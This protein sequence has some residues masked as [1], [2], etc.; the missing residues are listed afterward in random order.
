MA[1]SLPP[2]PPSPPS[3]PP[4]PPPPPP[5]AVQPDPLPWEKPDYPAVE[6][7]YETAKLFL[8]N[9]TAA[10]ARMS[11]TGSL[12]R[13]L[14][15]AIILGWVGIIFS[16]VWSIAFRSVIQ[17]FLASM[18]NYK[19]DTSLFFGTFFS[20]LFVVIAPVITLLLVFVWSVVLHLLLMIF[21]GT[22]RPLTVTIRVVCYG[23][24]TQVV[25]FVPLL[26]GIIAFVW[27]RTLEVIGLAR[28]HETTTSR[29]AAAVL[30]PM[31]LCCVCCV[32]VFLAALMGIISMASLGR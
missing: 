3:I 21:A 15:F 19:A 18:P 8:L 26:G 25:Q 7:L 29:S 4:G 2:A 12:W 32:C 31:G 13:P 5:P 28:A 17:G 16:Q 27:A 20:I 6:G 30:V 24:T 14:L 9:P 11:T 1:A 10:F 23:V 22:T